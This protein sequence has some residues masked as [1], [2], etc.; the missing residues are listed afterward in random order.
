M[1]KIFNFKGARINNIKRKSDCLYFLME[2]AENLHVRHQ[3][4]IFDYQI[5]GKVYNLQLRFKGSDIMVYNHV[6][7]NKEYESLVKL[8]DVNYRNPP[9]VIIDA[10]ANIGLT[11]IYFKSKYPE[12]SVFLIEPEDANFAIARRNIGYNN[13]SSVTLF[14]GALWS[15]DEPLKIIN[16]FRDQYDW[17]LRVEKNALGEIAAVTPFDVVS[18]LDGVIDIFKIDI[19]GGESQI[20]SIDADLTWL[21]Y[22]KVLAIEIHDEFFIR[23]RIVN[24]LLSNN[25]ILSSSG[26]LT[27]GVNKNLIERSNLS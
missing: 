9:K 16:D 10:G 14:K 5:G 22:V 19:E 2:H 18:R 26:E 6:I 3:E 13:I 17:S 4:V 24:V 21:N 15:K 23:E 8:Y 20:F 11:T 25:F 27:I 1:G 7:I 12:A